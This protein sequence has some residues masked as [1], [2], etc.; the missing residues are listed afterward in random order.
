V[1]RKPKPEKPSKTVNSLNTHKE[2]NGWETGK[3]CKHCR[4]LRDEGRN[5]RMFVK[6]K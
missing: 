6:C 3:E 2:N 4:N 1:F 5:Q